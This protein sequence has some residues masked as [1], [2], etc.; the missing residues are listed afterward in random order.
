MVKSGYT[1][2]LNGPYWIL[3]FLGSP[4]LFS[5]NNRS[6][7]RQNNLETYGY[8]SLSDRENTENCARENTWTSKTGNKR[9]N[10]KVT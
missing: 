9:S 2:S 5:D 6:I 1:G 4:F 3:K 7:Y 8:L 10:V